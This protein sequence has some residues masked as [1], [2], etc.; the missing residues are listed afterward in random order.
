M[1]THAYSEA[2]VPAL[3]DLHRRAFPDFFLSRLGVGFLRQFYL[4]YIGDPDAVVSVARAEDGRVVGVCV[5]T[6]NP[7]GFF[8]R[9]LKARFFGF[10]GASVR[11]ILRTPR[12]A[13][14]LLAALAY[15]GDGAPGQEGALLSSL[16]VDPEARSAGTGRALEGAWRERAAQLG[17][18]Q[19]FL[20]TDAADNDAVNRFYERCGWCLKD[21]FVTSRGRA[22]NR[23]WRDLTAT[24]ASTTATDPSSFVPFARPDIGEAEIEAVVTALR[25]GW[26]TTGPNC[27]AFEQ[28]FAE[29]LGGGVHALAVNSATAG[30]HLAV[31]GLGLGPGDEV[32]VPTWTFTSTA[33][34]VRYTGATPVMVDVDPVT[35]N[36]DLAAAERAVNPRTRAVIPVH[37]AGLPLDRAALTTF[38]G[39]HGLRTVEDAAHAFPVSS[40]GRLVGNG[41]SDAVVFSFYATKTITTGEGGMLVTPDPELATRA[42]TMRLHGINRDVFDRYHSQRPN[43]QYDVVAAGYKYNLTDT[44]AAMGRVQLGRAV[45]MREARARIASSYHESFGDLPVTLPVGGFSGDHAWHLYILRLHPDAPLSRDDFVAELA[46]QGI[47][48]SVHFTPLHMLSQ[49]RDSYGLRNEDFP[50]ATDVFSQVVSLPLFSTMTDAQVGRVIQATRSALG[51]P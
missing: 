24:A 31:D 2:D 44:A 17:A 22:M 27:A 33:E 41:E 46:R 35:L 15:R 42:R 11:A 3:A 50:V 19:A 36:L 20:T 40:Q 26:L 12:V 21:Q 25:S 32:I 28:E 30:L 8:S 4:G 38:A 47:G 10:V 1:I 45:A 51:E 14:R 16:C 23:Y 5:G 34:V 13:P 7:S 43:W 39:R 9:L 48:T 37:F 49:W 29:F 6:T 18:R